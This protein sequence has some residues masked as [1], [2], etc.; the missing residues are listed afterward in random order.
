[1]AGIATDGTPFFDDPSQAHNQSRTSGTTRSTVPQVV[2]LGD[3]DTPMP[4]RRDSGQL[5]L[6]PVEGN[7]RF[8]ISVSS[9]SSG[10]AGALVENGSTPS[11]ERDSRELKEFWRQYMRMPLSGSG[12]LSSEGVTPNGNVTGGKA[13][14]TSGLG[15][16]YRRQRVASLPAVKTPI[17]EGD[18]FNLGYPNVTHQNFSS[19]PGVGDGHGAA[20]SAYVRRTSREIPAG[21]GVNMDTRMSGEDLTS[22]EAAVMARKAPT[23]LNLKVKK[24]IRGSGR[25]TA[26]GGGGTL[27]DEGSASASSGDSPRAIGGG[28]G[29]T[30]T[31]SDSSSSSLAN[32]F[33]TGQQPRLQSHSRDQTV[34]SAPAGRMPFDRAKKEE[35]SSPSLSSPA[36]V[37]LEVEQVG[38]LG[39]GGGGGT[40][41]V[42]ASGRP[43]FKRLPS[44]TL[45]P[46]NSK[47]PFYGFGYD[48]GDGLEDRVAGGWGVVVDD[49][50]N[51]QPVVVPVVDSRRDFLVGGGVAERR[52]RRRRMSEPSNT[53]VVGNRVDVS[54]VQSVD[55]A[56]I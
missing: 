12:T 24:P 11:R 25:A 41:D 14:N 16:G 56:M 47:R 28:G 50:N 7:Q 55:E 52:M 40:L 15:P 23:T 45:G 17:V 30:T 13:T 53:G 20:P 37:D 34:L 8:P 54:A 19:N 44:Q 10:T 27:K 36:S 42:S 38:E 48:D 18:H 32:A 31:L 33:G 39:G 35:S 49:N 4:M 21:M 3:M 9:S 2:Q 22:Y 26:G 5:P 1:M 46:D 51:K 29:D 43:S 6:L